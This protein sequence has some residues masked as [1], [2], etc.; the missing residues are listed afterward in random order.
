MKLLETSYEVASTRTL[1]LSE[2]G[3]K[4]WSTHRTMKWI[5]TPPAW[6]LRHRSNRR[7]CGGTPSRRRLASRRTSGTA[8]SVQILSEV[9]TKE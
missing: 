5:T 1:V 2:A 6:L 3:T 9:G 4:E 8:G 7:V